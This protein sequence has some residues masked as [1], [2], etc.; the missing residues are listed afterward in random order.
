MRRPA[1]IVA[2]IAFFFFGAAMSGLS[3]IALLVPG[4]ILKGVWNLNPEAHRNLQAMGSWGPVLMFAVCAACASSA[5]GLLQR[6][7]WGHRLAVGL[8][9]VNMLA[10]IGN[11][12]VRGDL[13]TLIG[14]PIAS[15]LIACLFSRKIRDYF[16]A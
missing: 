3:A 1:G 5:A 11:A 14:V 12:L 8:L 6:A 9:I 2:L 15:I 13:R 10:D 7:A 4:G 16:R